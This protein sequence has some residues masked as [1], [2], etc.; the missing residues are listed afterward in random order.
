MSFLLDVYNLQT[1]QSND[2]SSVQGHAAATMTFE[3]QL[4]NSP[5]SNQ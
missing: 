3:Y 4:S 5:L 1:I 2:E